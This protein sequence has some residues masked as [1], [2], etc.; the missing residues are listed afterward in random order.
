M[1]EIARGHQALAASLPLG[2]AHGAMTRAFRQDQAKAGMASEIISSMPS[3]GNV[4]ALALPMAGTIAKIG[5]CLQSQEIHMHRRTQSSRAI[6]GLGKKGIQAGTMPMKLLKIRF[7]IKFA[8]S[9]TACAACVA[10]AAS[11][12]RKTRQLP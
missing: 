12:G 2:G 11:A 5:K 7:G 4:K 10:R 6:F 1:D 8:R 3:F 9:S